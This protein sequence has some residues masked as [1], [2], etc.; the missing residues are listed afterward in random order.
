[1]KPTAR[2]ARERLR[3]FLRTFPVVLVVGPR[4][5]GKTTMVRSELPGFHHVDL[6]RAQD[7]ARLSDDLPGFFDRH[8]KA[9]VIDEAQRMPEIFAALRPVIDRRQGKG[10]YV[11]TGSASPDLMRGVSESLAGRVGILELSPFSAFELL[12]APQVALRQFWGGYPP[13]LALRSAGARRDWLESYVQT[14]LE[15]DLPA[16]GL[17]LAATRLRILW[18]M[19]THVHGNLLN[20]SDLARSTGVSVPTIQSNLDILEQTFMI[21]RLPPYFANIQKRLTKS[22]K[23]YIRDTGLLHHL[24]GIRTPVEL[25]TW[26]RRGASFEGL[27]I[28][29]LAGRARLKDAT[30]RAY[31]WGTQAGGEVDLLLTRGRR[32]TP[33]EIKSGS[34]VDP[35]ELRALRACM[36][37]LHL[38]RAFVVYRGAETVDLG[39]GITA[40]PWAAGR[41]AEVL[42]AA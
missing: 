10:R 12:R 17:R 42:L 15:R 40:L 4:Q 29:E 23:L 27:V 21:R 5:C 25:E 36:S 26:D 1:M 22:P 19:L 9:V 8:P 41:C 3:S 13:A 31:F 34:H 6:E 32:V 7:F 37:D 2:E 28:E 38:K 24:A 16:L 39:H 33:I 30:S 11:L 35:R 18:T 20:M 14:F